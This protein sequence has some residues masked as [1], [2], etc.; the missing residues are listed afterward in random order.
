MLIV[1]IVQLAIINSSRSDCP[2]MCVW[3]ASSYFEL[4]IS[5]L[6]M[7]SIDSKHMKYSLEVC[8]CLKFKVDIWSVKMLLDDRSCQGLLGLLCR[9]KT[10]FSCTAHW[11]ITYPCFL[12]HSC[13]CSINGDIYESF[14]QI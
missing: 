1:L 12:M 10:Y 4:E 5:F 11:S 7:L 3:W 6:L 14:W 9:A 8:W 13:I 2:S